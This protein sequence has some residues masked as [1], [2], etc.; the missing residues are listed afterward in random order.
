LESNG[1]LFYELET[2]TNTDKK[3]MIFIK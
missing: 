1:V 3:K 2:P